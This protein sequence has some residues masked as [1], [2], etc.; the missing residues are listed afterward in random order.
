MGGNR[1]FLLERNTRGIPIRGYPLT[2][3][4]QGRMR[5]EDITDLDPDP[6]VQVVRAEG[7]LCAL[8]FYQISPA[9]KAFVVRCGKSE[10]CLPP[11]KLHLSCCHTPHTCV[12]N[13]KVN[14]KMQSL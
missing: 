10:E 3:E 8:C 12:Q 6:S 9:G 13:E 5:V 14:M 11:T 1:A 4:G 7:L 2:W